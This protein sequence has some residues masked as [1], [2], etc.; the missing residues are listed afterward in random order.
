MIQKAVIYSQETWG[1]MPKH[2]DNPAWAICP[3]CRQRLEGTNS[4]FWNRGKKCACGAYVGIEI[5]IKEKENDR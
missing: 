2:E 5:A 3:F 4:E 1:I